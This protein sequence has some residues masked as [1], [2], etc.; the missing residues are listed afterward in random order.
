MEITCL[1]EVIKEVKQLA[2][3][4]YK[5]YWSFASSMILIIHGPF[6]Y[7]LLS[8]PWKNIIL[9]NVKKLFVLE[10]EILIAYAALLLIIH[11]CCKNNLPFKICNGWVESLP[12]KS[13]N[14][15]S[16]RFPISSHYTFADCVEW[17][18]EL[19]VFIISFTCIRYVE[20]TVYYYL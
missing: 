14:I 1:L 15:L 18:D 2:I 17:F 16:R 4:I 12:N 8:R 20:P 10:F 9:H 5:R 11:L 13:Q 6:K 19:K 3:P 7:R